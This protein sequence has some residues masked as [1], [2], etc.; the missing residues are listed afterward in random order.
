LLREREREGG[1]EPSEF[2][3]VL[4]PIEGFS[5][6]DNNRPNIFHPTELKAFDKSSITKINLQITIIKYI[7]FSETLYL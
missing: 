1:R 5:K 4:S 6:K 3:N 7:A 2:G